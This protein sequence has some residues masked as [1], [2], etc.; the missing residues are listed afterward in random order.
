MIN[1]IILFAKW[2]LNKKKDQEKPLYFIEL[3]SQLK[4]KLDNIIF[5]NTLK[6]RFNK[7]WQK[8]LLYMLN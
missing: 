3:L 2:C 5:M 8:L 7:D 4:N 1:Y 6:D